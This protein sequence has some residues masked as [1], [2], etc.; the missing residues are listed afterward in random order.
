MENLQSKGDVSSAEQQAPAKKTKAEKKKITSFFAPKSNK[1]LVD[2]NDNQD[3]KKQK[4]YLDPESRL[5][6]TSGAEKS[7][8]CKDN[9]SAV[10]TTSG[11]E[12]S[13][14][15]ARDNSSA[16]NAWSS[17]FNKAAVVAP[18]CA[19]HSE[20]CVRRKVTKHTNFQ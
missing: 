4:D 12:K 10:T 3:L 7:V 16:A 14:R 9:P 5:A 19:G 15:S 17:M 8:M 13:V 11:A 20:P 1:N 18:A 2:S 6:P